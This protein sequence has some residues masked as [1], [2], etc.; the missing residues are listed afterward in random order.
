MAV[1]QCL[2]QLTT[3]RTGCLRDAPRS[4]A[5]GFK[6]VH[7]GRISGVQRVT[8]DVLAAMEE[9]NDVAPAHNP[10]YIAAMRLLAQTS[11]RRSRWWPP[12]RRASTPRFRTARGTTAIPYEWAEQ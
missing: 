11:C 8:A 12:S 2:E 4:S 10:P 1:R 7:G 3:R 5:I 9:M 6:A